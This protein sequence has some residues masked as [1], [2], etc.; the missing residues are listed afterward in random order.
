MSYCGNLEDSA[1]SSAYGGGLACDVSEG[2]TNY[3][4]HLS[5]ILN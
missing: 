1:E 4:V 3:K 5:G 2:S